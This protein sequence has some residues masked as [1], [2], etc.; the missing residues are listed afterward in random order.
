MTKIVTDD[1]HLK[2]YRLQMIQWYQQKLLERELED[3]PSLLGHASDEG[4]YR[5][6]L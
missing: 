3:N 4:N 1:G 5:C 6:R 2:P